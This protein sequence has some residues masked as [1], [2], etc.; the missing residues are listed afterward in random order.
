MDLH[1]K[2]AV[3][4]DLNKFMERRAKGMASA[5]TRAVRST[6]LGLQRE[7]RRQVRK[8]KFK[9]GGLEKLV[10]SKVRPE[11][12][13]APD[14]EGVVYSNARVQRGGDE[15][16]LLES[17]DKAQT[18]RAKGG[19]W[20]AIATEYA[21][22][23][24]GRGRRRASPSK[25]SPGVFKNLTFIKTKKPNLAMLAFVNPKTGDKVVA[26]WL[27]KQVNMRKRIDIKRAESKWL[28]KLEGK[29]NRNLDRYVYR[30]G[31]DI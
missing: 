14:A 22:R 29:I 10:S 3:V 12:G 24:S 25:L 16:D 11:K 5:V 21:P 6:T 20:L 26:Y 28:P 17:F 7:L 15:V 27:V 30:T 18:V 1:L 19:K 9:S 2:L 8:A 31:D 4:G 13:Y 23:G